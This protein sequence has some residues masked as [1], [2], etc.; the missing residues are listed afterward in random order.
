MKKP[1][2]VR[3]V[4]LYRLFIMLFYGEK[5]TENQQSRKNQRLSIFTPGGCCN[6][7]IYVYVFLKC[8]TDSTENKSCYIVISVL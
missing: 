3:S 8:S 5:S 7:K 6:I 1:V 2:F 4:P